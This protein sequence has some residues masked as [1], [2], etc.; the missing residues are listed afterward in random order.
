M[1]SRK[2]FTKSVK[3]Y[4]YS[5][6][7]SNYIPWVESNGKYFFKLKGWGRGMI[8]EDDFSPGVK[9]PARVW[10]KG[11]TVVALI[12]PNSLNVLSKSEWMKRKII[13]NVKVELESNCSGYE[14]TVSFSLCQVKKRMLH[15]KKY[16]VA[17]ISAGD[18][19]MFSNQMVIDPLIFPKFS[20]SIDF[21]M[22][23]YDL[24]W[25]EDFALLEEVNLEWG[26]NKILNIGGIDMKYGEAT[27]PYKSYHI[28]VTY[29]D[30]YF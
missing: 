10:S 19:Y 6:R 18:E 13:H 9:G 22:H 25:D 29:S 21:D 14:E 27:K 5:V 2:I 7:D 20:E 17:K 28:T 1:T 26:N 11:R 3:S 30:G 24:P 4:Y 16:G 8:V 15:G 12:L 23:G